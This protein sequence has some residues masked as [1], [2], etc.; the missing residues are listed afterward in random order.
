[1]NYQ[2]K[3]GFIEVFLIVAQE[4]FR[5]L[6]IYFSYLLF[7]PGFWFYMHL[8]TNGQSSFVD[9]NAE[10]FFYSFV[11]SL[12]FTLTILTYLYQQLFPARHRIAAKKF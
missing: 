9:I 3:K 4:L 12:A 11:C 8:F 7:I 2:Y 10:D 6:R 5:I 1:M